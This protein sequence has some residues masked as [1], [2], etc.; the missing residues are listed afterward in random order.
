MGFGGFE[1]RLQQHGE[2][3][4]TLLPLLVAV[5]CLAAEPAGQA[6]PCSNGS[7]EQ[8]APNGFP[9]DWAPLGKV[10]VVGDAHSGN[11]ALRLLR[12]NE[13]PTS[14]TGINGRN[15]DR[16]RGGIDFHY[17]AVAAK[18]AVL[19]IYAIPIAADGIEKPGGPRAGS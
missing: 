3:P 1:N 6:N 17:K 10:E 11:R 13:P 18:D 15:I 9:V 7:F 19:H 5:A 2:Q 4:M 16:L 14:E 12:T 8:L